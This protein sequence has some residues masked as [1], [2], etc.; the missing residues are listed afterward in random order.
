MAPFRTCVDSKQHLKKN[1]TRG[2]NGASAHDSTSNLATHSPVIRFATSPAHAHRKAI[3]VRMT[4]IRRAGDRRATP[5][6][7]SARRAIV[8]TTPGDRRYDAGK[9]SLTTTR[10]TGIVRRF[11]SASRRTA[12]SRRRS[13]QKSWSHRT[14]AVCDDDS[15][16]V[17][18]ELRAISRRRSALF[19]PRERARTGVR[20]DRRP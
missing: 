19:G 15:T 14:R 4:P 18:A 5:A 7:A 13:L 8:S 17:R 3:D 20:D 12:V 1:F 16:R 9:T 2:A 6:I 11:A 10:C